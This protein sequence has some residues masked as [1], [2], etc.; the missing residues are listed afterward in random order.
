MKLLIGGRTWE[1]ARPTVA[2]M[3]VERTRVVAVQIVAHGNK[4]DGF[5]EKVAESTEET[6]EAVLDERFLVEKVVD[7]LSAELCKR[8]SRFLK[9]A[10]PELLTELEKLDASSRAGAALD[11][12]AQ[13]FTDVTGGATSLK[14]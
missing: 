11:V 9:D 13:V 14:N 3:D 2:Q 4:L 5:A 6:L 1:C 12:F 10:C 8:V 7:K